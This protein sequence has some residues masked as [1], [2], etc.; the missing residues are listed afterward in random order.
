MR[1]C[2]I[3]GTHS[4]SQLEND[5]THADFIK[6]KVYFD[7]K[8]VGEIIDRQEYYPA[9]ILEFMSAYAGGKTP[10]IEKFLIKFSQE[11]V[12]SDEDQED[13][14]RAREQRLFASIDGFNRKKKKYK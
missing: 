9:R 2:E 13:K 7:M 11:E 6:W 5:L 3:S 12:L 1:I 10:P 4:L 8:D 14:A